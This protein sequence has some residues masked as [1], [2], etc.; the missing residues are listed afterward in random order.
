MSMTIMPAALDFD[1]LNVEDDEDFEVIIDEPHLCVVRRNGMYAAEV[2]TPVDLG[3][4]SYHLASFGYM[5]ESLIAFHDGVIE[6]LLRPLADITTEVPADE[7]QIR[8]DIQKFMKG[9]ETVHA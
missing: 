5:V 1:V 8:A 4:L 9:R 2:H 3:E 6:M 7:V